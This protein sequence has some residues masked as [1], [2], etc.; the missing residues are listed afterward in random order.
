MSDRYECI[1]SAVNRRTFVI[2]YEGEDGF[3]AMPQD[4]RRRGPWTDKQTGEVMRLKPDYRLALAKQNYVL[5]ENAPSG[6][7]PEV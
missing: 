5:I 7:K 2:H 3:Y 6:W 4:M 1:R